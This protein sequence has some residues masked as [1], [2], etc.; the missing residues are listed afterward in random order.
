MPLSLWNILL[1]LLLPAQ[2]A[3]QGLPDVP[4]NDRG[5]NL[6][7]YNTAKTTEGSPFQKNV[8]TVLK[9]FYEHNP[10]NGFATCLGYGDFPNTVYGHTGC[11]NMSDQPSCSECIKR[12]Y[13]GIQQYALYALGGTYWI[14]ETESRCRLRYEN[15]N[16]TGLTLFGVVGPNNSAPAPAPIP[17]NP[18]PSQAR[19]SI[20][21]NSSKNGA[22]VWGLV[23][24]AVGACVLL[25]GVAFLLW[26]RRRK[27][28][29]LDGRRRYHGNTG[30][31][32]S[33]EGPV[34]FKYQDLSLATCNFSEMN[35]LGQ[36]GF[37]TVYK[38]CLKDGSQ[39]AVKKLSLQSSQ[40][41]QE[42]VN[43]INIITSIQHRNL[44]R[45]KGYCVERDQRLL[46]YEFLNNGS[47]DQALFSPKT[48]TLNWTS[49]FHIVTGVARG[50]AYLHEESHI[51][52]IHRDIKASNILLDDKLQPKISDFGI[53]KLF[54]MDK[55]FTSTKVA[56]T[57]GYMAPEYATRGRLSS[58]ADVFSFGILA[59]EIVSGR[60]CMDP[61][62][63]ASQELLVQMAWNMWNAGKMVEFVDK[64][65]D[66]NYV[67]E[68]VFRVMDVAILCTQEG[69]EYRPMM[70]DVVAMLM[71]YLEIGQPPS[72]N[73]L[74]FG[75]G[76]TSSTSTTT[77]DDTN[78]TEL[79]GR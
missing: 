49:R 9:F 18:P 77:V 2:F 15:Y 60:R 57:V 20:L 10:P 14:N 27:Y 3:A 58:K 68:E 22:L 45:L 17:P 24:G 54:D 41:R 52:I 62:L 74:Y 33:I 7:Y 5:P 48:S 65:L 76:G 53:S 36:G 6:I 8:E 44:A 69:E 43:E 28:T 38:A 63:S 11:Y 1:V 78:I 61:T 71:G 31:E 51:Q 50:L 79:E 19:P 26:R 46:V 42:F 56:G 67:E 25:A 32:G 39:V 12:A 35:K 30:L 55:G 13:Q 66:G 64:R 4:G 21:Q 59:L 75:G 73:P 72:Q 23:G 40:G 29:K 16:L 70:S 34:V 37:G 47:L